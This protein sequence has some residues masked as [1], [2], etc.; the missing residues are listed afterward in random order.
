MTSRIPVKAVP[1]V[2][3]DGLSLKPA[4]A[5]VLV[6][7]SVTHEDDRGSLCEVYGAQWGFDDLPLVHAYMVTVRPGRVKGWAVHDE[8][9]DRYFFVSGSTKLVLY[10][11]R[12]ESPTHGLVTVSYFSE[13]NRSLVLVPPGVYHAV[14]AIG[15]TDSLLFNIPSRPYV[16]DDPDKHTLPLDNDLIPYSF[17]PSRGY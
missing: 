8:Q 9:V 10:D 15:A 1:T 7:Q 11:G 16:H 3:R 13:T 14:E 4:I 5:G 12:A 2:T 6:R 17:A